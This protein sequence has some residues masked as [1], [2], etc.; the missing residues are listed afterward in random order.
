MEKNL[1]LVQHYRNTVPVS[2][3]RFLFFFLSLL[4]DD[5]ALL[6]FLEKPLRDQTPAPDDCE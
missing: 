1:F 4:H 6:V 5:S 3:V 2:D